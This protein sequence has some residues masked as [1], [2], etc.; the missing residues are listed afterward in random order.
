[1]SKVVK[2]MIVGLFLFAGIYGA[3]ASQKPDMVN[4]KPLVEQGDGIIMLGSVA[5]ETNG[6]LVQRRGSDVGYRS[7]LDTPIDVM[8]LHAHNVPTTTI[9]RLEVYDDIHEVDNVDVRT[10]T[11]DLEDIEDY[12]VVMVYSDGSFSDAEAMGDLLADYFDGGG[13]IIALMFCFNGAIGIE[14]RIVEDEYL[15]VTFG[16]GQQGGDEMDWFDDT[17]PIMEDVEATTSTY[18]ATTINLA[19]DAD[20]VAEYEDGQLFVA[21][22]PQI[23]AMNSY[24]GENQRWTGDM[25]IIL[26]NAIVWAFEGG[27]D[28]DA[29]MEGTVT[30]EVTGDEVEDAIVRLGAARDTTDG[31]GDYLMDV[32]SG[33]DRTV[34]VIKEHYYTHVDLIDVEIGENFFDFEITPLATLTGIITDSETDE[35]IEGA[36]ITWGDHFDTT[37]AEGVYTL[38]DMEAA[39]DTLVIEM[40]GYFDYEDLEYEVLDGDN[41]EDFAIDILSADLTGIVIDEL[42]EEALFGATVT[43][44]TAE[45]GDIYR[46]VVTDETGAYTAPALHDG[47]TY[48]VN[49]TLDGYA[50]SDV[51]DILI[52]WNRD[53][54][55][56]FE[57]TPIFELGIRQLQQEQDTETWVLTTGI[58]TQGSNVTDTEQTSIYIQDD[59]GWGIMLWDENPW[60]PENNINRGDDITVVGFLIEVDDMTRITNFE[61]VVNSNDNALPDPLVET[62][63]DMS[64]NSQREGTWGQ[65]SGQINRDP[66]GEGTYS[67][68][69]NDGSGQCE[70][71]IIEITGIDMSAFSADDWGTFTGVISL[72]RQGLRLIPNMQDDVTRIPVDPPSDLTSEQ[73]VV[74]GDPLQ[75]EVTLSWA[76]DH[77]D[78]WLRFKI[79]RDGEHIGNTQQLTWSEK[80]EDPV[81]GEFGSYTYEYGVT[82][83]Y[84]EGETDA[85]E[86]E[87]I[88]DITLV[89][90]R[91]YSGVPTDWALEAVYPNP[92]NPTLHVVLGVPQTSNVTVEIMDILG[93]RVTVLHQ[94]ELNAAYHR[95]GWNATGHPTGLYFLRVTSNTGFNQISKVMFIK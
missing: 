93:R 62:T 91:P 85:T 39:I 68:V 41:E 58:V 70:V 95:V 16:D 1:M 18:R 80:L 69:I 29:T 57:L 23:V 46:E 28:P 24:V 25:D 43:V 52:R 10:T 11:P 2:I 30:D 3:T 37:D 47:V 35:V 50:P 79:Y 20:L 49:V 77:L 15:P 44:A 59:S 73:E 7:E 22:K 9:G 64:G 92:F 63:G 88:W 81:P 87:V 83:V 66:P 40:E 21:V 51:E 56:D 6:N 42:T 76:H 53:N 86:I 33:E 65:I 45:T 19:D 67:L 82:A 90:E 84:D 31:N 55:Q 48:E 5:V 78:E 17:H 94:G 36:I 27:G 26:H 60:D 74:P 4:N 13:A 34:R 75:L 14:G 89:H 71:Q 54:E 12:H 8:V 32:V 61:I 72:S 38:I